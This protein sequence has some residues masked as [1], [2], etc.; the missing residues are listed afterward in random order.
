VTGLG[1]YLGITT[2]QLDANSVLRKLE[3]ILEIVSGILNNDITNIDEAVEK[4]RTILASCV[5]ASRDP[6]AVFITSAIPTFFGMILL[7]AFVRTNKIEYLN[8]SVS[9][10]RRLLERPLLPFIRFWILHGLS[11][12]L[13]TRSEVI[14]GFST[15]QR[16][17][18]LDEA[19]ELLSQCIDDKH[20]GFSERCL[21]HASGHLLR[22]IM[23]IPLPPRH[24]RALCR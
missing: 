8:E 7:Q 11:L 20:G 12:S 9:I 10:Y 4:G 3:P 23:D 18:D 15:D 17:K 24:T 19:L 14:P 22:E 13:L 16:R 2:S 1:K 6:Y 5:L 21:L